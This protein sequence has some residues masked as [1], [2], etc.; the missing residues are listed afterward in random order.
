MQRRAFRYPFVYLGVFAASLALVIG[1]Y[2]IFAIAD[3][4]EELALLYLQ[5][6]LYADALL[7][8]TGALYSALLDGLDH[9]FSNASILGLSLR[10]SALW[11]P[12]ALAF[13]VWACMLSALVAPTHWL[14]ASR[15]ANAA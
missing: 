9:V 4:P 7:S 8:K 2:V 14:I 1:V 5:P 13:L 10:H 11:L 6:G 15:R 12:I 3:A